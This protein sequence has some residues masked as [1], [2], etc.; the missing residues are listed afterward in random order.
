MSF[1][2]D[3]FFITPPLKLPNSSSSMIGNKTK[4]KTMATYFWETW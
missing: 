4:N 2:R 1:I 3:Y